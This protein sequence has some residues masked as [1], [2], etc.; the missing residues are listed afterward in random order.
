VNDRNR[1][2]LDFQLCRVKDRS[3]PDAGA[4]GAKPNFQFHRLLQAVGSGLS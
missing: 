4:L 3:Q 2:L 1:G